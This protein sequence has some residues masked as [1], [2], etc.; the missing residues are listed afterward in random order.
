MY[1][2]TYIR[3]YVCMYIHTFICIHTNIHTYNIRAIGLGNTNPIAYNKRFFNGRKEFILV[4]CKTVVT[5]L[6]ELWVN[7][8]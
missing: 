8:F 6:D 5:H 4:L 2:H 7:Y 1:V 3:M